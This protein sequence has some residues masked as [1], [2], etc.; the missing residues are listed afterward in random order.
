[1]KI[2]SFGDSFIY[3]SEVE[4]NVNGQ[5]AWPGL[6][7]NKLGVE[8][9]TL[10][11]PGCSNENITRQILSYFSEYP[12]EQTLAVINWTW[13]LRYDIYLT[14]TENWTTLGPTCVPRNLSGSVGEV[15][16]KKLLE[17]YR[18]YGGKSILWD[19]FRALQTMYTAQQILKDLGVKSVQTTIDLSIFDTKFHAPNYIV[20]LQNLVSPQIES[21]NGLSFLDW[22]YANQYPVST[23]G[24][25]PSLK[26]HQAACELWLTRYSNELGC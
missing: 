23:I 21:F 26:A 5:N 6:I 22:S 10:A 24:L 8:Y 14:E 25:H 19:R 17:F 16:S 13:A 12:T 9:Q 20:K 4:G 1:M 15:E 2:V 7:A 3:G 11:V 18:N